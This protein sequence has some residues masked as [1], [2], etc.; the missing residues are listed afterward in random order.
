M[1]CI[2]T[3]RKKLIIEGHFHIKQF[4]LILFKIHSIK[5]LESNK[6]IEIVPYFRFY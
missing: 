2:S 1:Y 3:D 6:H 4:Y 5:Q